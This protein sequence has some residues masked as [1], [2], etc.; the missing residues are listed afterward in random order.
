ME[1]GHPVSALGRVRAFYVWR[2]ALSLLSAGLLVTGRCAGNIAA[3]EDDFRRLRGLCTDGL[4]LLDVPAGP[5]ISA[6]TG[7]DFFFFSLCGEPL[8]RRS[9]L[10]AKC[11]CGVARGRF[12]A[13]ASARDFARSR[14]GSPDS[15]AAQPGGGSRVADERSFRSDGELLAGI[16]DRDHGDHLPPAKIDLVRCICCRPGSGARRLLP[17]P[18]GMGREMGEYRP[19]ARS[20]L[21]SNNFSS[22]SSTMWTTTASTWWC[23]W[24]EHRKSCSLR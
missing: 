20:R 16:T 18:R 13:A 15:Y 10:L 5:A 8:L 9:D 24:W 1:A 14:Q 2:S 23:H 4:R 21:R 11:T 22:R 19:S 6:S 12:I 7:R 17:D 3:L